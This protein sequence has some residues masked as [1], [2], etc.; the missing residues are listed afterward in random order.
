MSKA[1]HNRIL[2][3]SQEEGF[4]NP[5]IA[6]DKHE[7]THQNTQQ[8][9]DNPLYKIVR[10]NGVDYLY[11]LFDDII[12]M[13]GIPYNIQWKDECPII[14]D[15]NRSRIDTLL[16]ANELAE[17]AITSY[18]AS[19]AKEGRVEQICFLLAQYTAESCSL[20]KNLRDITRFP[21]DIQKK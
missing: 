2:Y 3:S 15:N 18:L 10:I 16:F 20:P 1:S 5:N 14:V 21:A 6:Y 8:F 12:E 7:N 11:N 13:N 17:L 4:S 19:L 9:S